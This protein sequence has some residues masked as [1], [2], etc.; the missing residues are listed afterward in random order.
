MKGSVYRR[1][2]ESESGCNSILRQS[3]N[4][5]ICFSVSYRAFLKFFTN[6]IT[7]QVV[8]IEFSHNKDILFLLKGALID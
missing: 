7:N 6:I 5:I 3:R 1:D 8:H 2:S 4:K